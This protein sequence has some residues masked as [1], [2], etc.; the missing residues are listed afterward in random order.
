MSL[1]YGAV[2]RVN[3]A[4]LWRH[5]LD[6]L[7][8]A[9]LPAAPTR[10][11]VAAP[12]AHTCCWAVC[13]P[14]P[15]ASAAISAPHPQSCCLQGIAV[16]HQDWQPELQWNPTLCVYRPSY[17]ETAMD[18]HPLLLLTLASRL[19]SFLAGPACSPDRLLVAFTMRTSCPD[20]SLDSCHLFVCQVGYTDVAAYPL[21][22]SAARGSFQHARHVRR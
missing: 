1:A 12:C 3:Q 11:L 22:L 7:E 4:L 15:H 13:P 19:L 21:L 8:A 17:L 18:L 9:D 20:G 2:Q 16:L 5:D 14:A 6:C 10:L